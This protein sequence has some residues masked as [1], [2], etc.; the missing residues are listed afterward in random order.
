[1]PLR[2]VFNRM[3]SPASTITVWN[4]LLNSPQMPLPTAVRPGTAM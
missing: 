3:Y 1:M 2:I 4:W